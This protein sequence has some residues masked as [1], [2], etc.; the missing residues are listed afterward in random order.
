VI[1]YYGDSSRWA[2]QAQYQREF[3]EKLRKFLVEN[4]YSAQVVA[5]NGVGFTVT[6][7]EVDSHE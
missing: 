4:G 2:L 7:E 1:E 6:R 5:P 3:A